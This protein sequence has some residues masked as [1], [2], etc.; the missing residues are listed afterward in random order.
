[1]STLVLTCTGTTLSL[2]P[3]ST[4]EGDAMNSFLQDLR[5]ATRMLAKTPG[6][7]IVAILTLALGIG[8]N[9]A[10]FSIVRAVLLRPLPYR[11]PGQLVRV[12]DD[13]SVKRP[14]RGNVRA[15]N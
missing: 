2:R 11:Q 9:V 4:W 14:R 8:A 1:M 15:R 6:F 10:A 12:F 5:Y 3:R 7:T 13:L